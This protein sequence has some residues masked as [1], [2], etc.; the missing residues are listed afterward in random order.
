M[1]LKNLALSFI[2]FALAGC[3]GGDQSEKSNVRPVLAAAQSAASSVSEIPSD[4]RAIIGLY[5]GLYGKAP[6]NVQLALFKT[7]YA[8]NSGMF[9]QSQTTASQSTTDAAFAKQVLDNFQ[10]TPSTVNASSYALLLDA[11]QQFFAAYG[12]AGRGQIVVNLAGLLSGLETDETYGVAAAR[13]NLQTSANYSYSIDPANSVDGIANVV[14]VVNATSVPF[15][16]VRGSWDAIANGNLFAEDSAKLYVTVTGNVLTIRAEQFFDGTCLYT[17]SLTPSRDGLNPGNFQCSDF[18]SGTWRLLAMQRVDQGDIYISLSTGGS[19]AKRLYGLASGG[20]G[21]A[22][23]LATPISS[24][25]GTYIGIAT[26][27]PFGTEP[28]SAIQLDVNGT[29]LTLTVARFF[30]G[31]CEYS[32]TIQADGRSIAT[33]TYRCSDFSTGTWTLND[34]RAI[35]G[36]DLYISLSAKGN[37]QRLYGI[38]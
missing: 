28:A 34:L 21:V 13:L 30:S 5:Q 22:Q 11:L 29:K 26:G 25:I 20:S 23:A 12:K 16:I 19:T 36:N 38:R 14:P 8:A 7:Q 27:G 37:L 15:E 35:G 10:V 4:A 2:V 33:P 31:K 6:S 1:K 3:G 18:T 17:A 32:A 24:L 9:F